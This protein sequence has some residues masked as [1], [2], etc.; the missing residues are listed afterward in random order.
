MFVLILYRKKA[1]L[2]E[3][4][5]RT[6]LPQINRRVGNVCSLVKLAVEDLPTWPVEQ[7][8]CFIEVSDKV[9]SRKSALYCLG[10]FK[11]TTD[12]TD[13]SGPIFWLN[14]W[15]LLKTAWDQRPLGRPL[16]FKHTISAS[17][18]TIPKCDDAVHSKNSRMS[19]L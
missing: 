16:S 7:N 15:V 11:P 8:V 3:F 4:L 13:E 12:K 9:H 6:H 18:R 2:W 10:K 14:L 1:C 19:S 5:R 17:C